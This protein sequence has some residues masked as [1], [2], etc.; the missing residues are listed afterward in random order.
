MRGGPTVYFYKIVLAWTASVCALSAGCN[1]GLNRT[2]ADSRVPIPRKSPPGSPPV[3]RPLVSVDNRDALKPGPYTFDV[4]SSGEATWQLPLWTPEGR[5]GIAPHLAIT[6]ESHRGSKG[7]LGKGFALS[8]LSSIARCWQTPASNGKYTPFGDVSSGISAGLPDTLCLDGERLVPRAA[9]AGDLQPE[10]DSGILVRITAG[11]LSAPLSFDVYHP[12]G[13]IWR[14]SSRD[15][16]SDH[17]SH[18][19]LKGVPIVVTAASTDPT[20]GAPNTDQVAET[21]AGSRSLEWYVDE[22]VDRWQNF[23]EIDYDRTTDS[24]LP[25][26]VELV[27]RFIRWTGNHSTPVIN[28]S[29]TVEFRYSA[30]PGSAPLVRYDSQVSYRG[31]LAIRDSRFLQ[32]IIVSG[33]DRLASDNSQA[34]AKP[35]AFREYGFLWTIDARN[36]VPLRLHSIVECADNPD[37]SVACKDPITFTWSEHPLPSFQSPNVFTDV[38]EFP[39]PSQPFPAQENET[40]ALAEVHEADVWYSIV[41]DFDGDGRDDLLYRMPRVGSDGVPAF[42]NINPNTIV[43][44]WFIRRGSPTGLG[45]RMKVSGIPPTPG[46]AWQFSARAI[47]IDSDGQAEVLAYSEPIDQADFSESG[48]Q[49]YRFSS[50]SADTCFF[51]G[52]PIKEASISEFVDGF[53]RRGAGVDMGDFNADGVLDLVR[54]PSTCQN[55]NPSLCPPPLPVTDLDDLLVR[56]SSD[57]SQPTQLGAPSFVT[58]GGPPTA[59]DLQIHTAE[60]RYIVDIDGNGVPEVLT[61]SYNVVPAN[62]PPKFT[63]PFLSS[64]SFPASGSAAIVSPVL[65]HSSPLEQS[66][67]IQP[68]PT[69][70]LQCQGLDQCFA[71]GQQISLTQFTRYFVDI[72]GDGLPDSVA[73][74]SDNAD[75]CPMPSYHGSEMYIALNAGGEFRAPTRIQQTTHDGFNTSLDRDDYRDPIRAAPPQPDPSAPVAPTSPFSGRAVDSGA[76]FVDLDGDGRVDI[77]QMSS[78]FPNAADNSV[79]NTSQRM[80]M[81]WIRST[82]AGFAPG[83]DLTAGPSHEP[84]PAAPQRYVRN[85]LCTPSSTAM[86]CMENPNGSYPVAGGY[87]ARL[88]QLGDFN[89]DGIL[90][91][92]T[93]EQVTNADADPEAWGRLTQYLGQPVSPDVVTRIDGGPLTPAIDVSYAFAGPQSNGFYTVTAAVDSDG[94]PRTCSPPPC[95]FGQT[96]LRKLGWVVE[97]YAEE[98]DNFADLHPIHNVY[99]YTYDTA[100]IDLRGR[101][102]LGVD[103]RNRILTNDDNTQ[104]FERQVLTFDHSLRSRVF[105]PGAVRYQ[106]ANVNTPAQELLLTSIQAGTASIVDTRHSRLLLPRAGGFG[107]DLAMVTTAE[108]RC[109]VPGSTDPFV[110]HPCGGGAKLLSSTRTRQEF[111]GFGTAFLH[112][113]QAAIN[114]S[115]LDANGV[116][117]EVNPPASFSTVQQLTGPNNADT[118]LWIT[119]RY[120]GWSY[121]SI[122][123][124]LDPSQQDLRQRGTISYVPN[125]VE[126]EY[127]TLEPVPPGG[128]ESDTVSGFTDTTVYERDSRLGVLTAI[129]ECTTT[130]PCDPIATRRQSFGFDSHDPDKIFFSTITDGLGHVI[131]VWPHATLGTPYAVEDE[132][133]VRTQFDYDVLGRQRF[134]QRPWGTEE[135]FTYL[136]DTRSDGSRVRSWTLSHFGFPIVET[137]VSYNPRGLAQT[138]VHSGFNHDISRSFSY[139]RF[140][141]LI[142][143]RLP[144]SPG[145][146]TP[147]TVDYVRD[148]LGRITQSSRPGETAMAPRLVS[149]RT[150]VGRTETQTSECIDARSSCHGGRGITATLQRD[151][152]GRTV[153]LSTA[154]ANGHSVGTQIE[155]WHFDLPR[156]IVHPTLPAAQAMTPSPLQP[157][158]VM[159]YDVL[160]RRIQLTDSDTGSQSY[161]YNS[162]GEPKRVTDG[163]GAVTTFARDLLGRVYRVQTAATTDYPARGAALAQDTAFNY[164]IGT[165]AIGK[166]SS[167]TSAEGISRSYEYDTYGRLHQE[168]LS[169]E[170]SASWPITYDYDFLGRIGTVTYPPT[171]AESSTPATFLPRAV[172]FKIQY[173]YTG[174]GDVQRVWDASANTKSLLWT[175]VTR[176]DADQSTVEQFGETE[177]MTRGFDASFNLRSV[178]GVFIGWRTHT[179]YQRLQYDWGVDNLL[180]TRTDLDLGITEN[181][182][183]DFLGRLDHWEVTQAC[184]I[185]HSPAGRL[186]T[187]PVAHVAQTN[188]FC[189]STEWQYQYDDWG[190]LRGTSVV[191]GTSFPATSLDYTTASDNSRP[192]AVKRATTGT[193][194]DSFTYDNAGQMQIG[195][196][197]TFR[198]TPFGLPFEIS[199]SASQRRSTYLYDGFDRRVV[200]KQG[201]VGTA[202]ID[203]RIVSFAGL[204]ELHESSAAGGP[205]V[206]YV[207]NVFGAD[208]LV[209]QVRRTRMPL[210]QTLQFVHPDHLGNPDAITTFRRVGFARLIG[211]LVERGKYEPFGERRDPTALAQP[212][213]ELHDPDASVGFTGQQPDDTFGLISMRGRLYRPQV[214]RFISPDPFASAHSQ[215]LN[216]YSYVWNSPLQFTDPSGYEGEGADAKDTTDES[217]AVDSKLSTENERQVSFG[218]VMVLGDKQAASPAPSS[219]SDENSPTKATAQSGAPQPS[220]HILYPDY[221]AEARA[222]LN[223][224]GTPLDQANRN[225]RETQAAKTDYGRRAGQVADRLIREHAEKYFGEYSDGALDFDVR[226]EIGDPPPLSYYGRCIVGLSC[227]AAGA[228]IPVAALEL[229]ALSVAPKI[230]RVIPIL[231]AGE[232]VAMS[233]QA[234]AILREVPAMERVAAYRNL[235]NQIMAKC[236]EPWKFTEDPWMG[237]RL[238]IGDRAKGYALFIDSLGNVQYGIGQAGFSITEGF[239]WTWTKMLAEF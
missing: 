171:P 2:T 135:G 168:L 26:A 13:E 176:N 216:R 104:T 68:A 36:V 71:G 111:D 160:G 180:A 43:G 51:T 136:N 63:A 211:Q 170:N 123:P 44:D 165:N 113:Q 158:T 27:P 109:E 166:L 163:N 95:D 74:P 151:S 133:R 147:L 3:F 167:V 125:H 134:I 12:N 230:V 97:H 101:G 146:G 99:R 92:V 131:T 132:N 39:L 129:S 46:G 118:G 107:F 169:D 89:G 197:N 218:P 233:R 100:R 128:P 148:G 30:L 7:I 225:Y 47:D 110:P 188:P 1:V 33:P 159:E 25:G 194:S 179:P 9:S 66:H 181:Y 202:A 235:A 82:E 196:G 130:A 139:D 67:V 62:G 192:H 190:N 174:S 28:P 200:E 164:D 231:E 60:P 38:I 5:N 108:D 34:N 149:F 239:Q 232:K 8:G 234:I 161:L 140:G 208:G 83:V 69:C 183:H 24:Q 228:V 154:D 40:A 144:F 152:K 102:F 6:Y 217:P 80:N 213:A 106:Y 75:A 52:L 72:N 223:R 73:V 77:V 112:Q 22:V 61:T 138:E 204:F 4:T 122:D 41:G 70:A 215:A 142:S 198:W 32:D 178:S 15:D 237:G 10:N 226:H 98:A 84:I 153:A 49:I 79:G 23:M 103:R 199:N 11:T 175:Q 185:L 55:P 207:Y 224:Y 187:D 91:I 205:A 116:V 16:E 186:P 76:R 238:F 31:G 173:D 155:Y 203:K 117:R 56:L 212:T 227:T 143:E 210:G 137:N 81:V 172:P 214:G 37:A 193:Q 127:L 86:T 90:D 64:V 206:E 236:T 115:F 94:N 157:D 229:R 105:Q 162:F 14:Y 42:A 189:N 141:S 177:V 222:A 121:Q 58:I 48:Y 54:N 182:K 87:G 20:N 184:R 220:Y 50:C 65:L 201:A 45:P 88:S 53:P 191:N 126:A 78:H 221:E 119:K 19:T 114:D 59:G 124:T 150:Y 209:A 35:T 85:S 93:L 145:S 18:A 195:A 120:A 219:T 96:V 29:R 156:H 21:L 57:P 17:S